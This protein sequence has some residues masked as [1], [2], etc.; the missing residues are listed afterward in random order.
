MFVKCLHPLMVLSPWAG[1]VAGIN[2]SFPDYKMGLFQTCSKGQGELY[3]KFLA[4][5]GPGIQYVGPKNN[6]Q[7]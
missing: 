2:L 6:P 5:S 1:H 4:A 7:T 3:T